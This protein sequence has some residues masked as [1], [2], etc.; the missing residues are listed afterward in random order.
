[1]RIVMKT[2]MAQSDR[3]IV[4]NNVTSTLEMVRN[5]S[6]VLLQW[7]G[8]GNCKSAG[9]RHLQ[10]PPN[11]KATKI[12]IRKSLFFSFA[13]EKIIVIGMLTSVLL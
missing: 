10:Q 3:K 13:R 12:I 5:H 11:Y 7:G 9:W 2:W 4:C 1:M 8:R 6:N